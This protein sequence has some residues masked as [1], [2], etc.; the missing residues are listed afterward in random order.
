[1]GKLGTYL[2]IQTL[3]LRK[4]INKIENPDLV[5]KI[6]IK[7]LENHTH[8]TTMSYAFKT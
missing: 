1:M 2:Y 7:G 4:Y 6:L 5:C 8:A 3:Q